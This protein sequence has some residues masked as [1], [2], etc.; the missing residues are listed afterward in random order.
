MSLF[1]AGRR[2]QADELRKSA[3][4]RSIE[5]HSLT[6]QPDGA[7]IPAPY[8]RVAF[9]FL[10]PPG[11]YSIQF[12][13]SEPDSPDLAKSLAPGVKARYFESRDGAQ[14]RV[15]ETEDGKVWWPH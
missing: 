7:G 13:E 5:I 1:N 6:P 9:T 12:F 8:Y 15:I 2:R 14:T 10:D 3:K 11:P 4:P